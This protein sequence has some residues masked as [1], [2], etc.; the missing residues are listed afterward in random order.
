MEANRKTNYSLAAVCLSSRVKGK[1]RCQLR[2]Y[3]FILTKDNLFQY[4]FPYVGVNFSPLELKVRGSN[5]GKCV[6]NFH[7]MPRWC[8]RG[9]I[10]IFIF[11]GRGG[12]ADKLCSFFKQSSQKAAK[13]EQKGSKRAE[14]GAKGGQTPAGTYS[15]VY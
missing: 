11:K 12:L 15:D 7:S 1:Q 8:N 14:T 5:P 6:S 4:L 13:K 3:C 10:V 2:R 9:G